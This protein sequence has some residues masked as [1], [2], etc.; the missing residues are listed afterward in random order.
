MIVFTSTRQPLIVRD[1]IA[2]GGEAIVYAV[3]RQPDAVAKIYTAQRDDYDRKLGWMIANPPDDPNQ[4]IGHPS[5]AWP[6]ERLYD[7]N[8]RLVGYLMPRI[9]GAVKLLEVFNPRL[10]AQTLPSFNWKYLHRA[11]RNLAS[12]LDALHARDYVVGDLNE[13]NILVMPTALVTLIDTDSFQARAQ[14]NGRTE[15][16]PCPVA[17]WEYTPPELQGR[18]LDRTPRLPEHDAF[19]L[20]VLIFQMLLNGSHPFRGRWLGRGDPP[21]IEERIKSGWFPHGSAAG[22]R[23]VPL[24]NML[25]LN[26]LDPTVA[27]LIE[28][29]FVE[30]HR[31]PRRRPTPDEWK[32]ALAAAEQ[33]LVECR[34]HHFFASHLSECPWCK[35]KRAGTQVPLPPLKDKTPANT[36]RATTSP[37]TK[38]R[39]TRT[40]VPLPPPPVPPPWTMRGGGSLA[41]TFP[42]P[43][44]R[45]AQTTLGKAI[46]LTPIAI[47]FALAV[48][49]RLIVVGAS[50]T[51]FLSTPDWN[52]F[53]AGA[54]TIGVG[55]LTTALFWAIIGV[56][57]GAGLGLLG[58]VLGGSFAVGNALN[59]MFSIGLW[60][61]ALAAVP[62]AMFGALL[63]GITTSKHVG[64]A[65]VGVLIG[66]MVATFAG[67]TDWLVFSSAGAL[68]G[69]LCGLVSIA[70]AVAPHTR[71]PQF[72]VDATKIVVNQL[73][74]ASAWTVMA[75]GGM[76]GICVSLVV[77]SVALVS[78]P[79]AVL[80]AAA[81]G[82][83][84]G[85]MVAMR[86]P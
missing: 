34:Q 5:I 4:S 52:A 11:A 12:A 10:R 18:A 1:P 19:G 55:A 46:T 15:L 6:R 71:G 60:G 33:K 85:T 51:R 58:A 40:F 45:F 32:V 78:P 54:R 73:S 76:V 65:L 23:I 3:Q 75:Y 66:V 72:A 56:V 62:G 53:N 28:R 7:A 74:N 27:A 81:A 79:F 77:W 48:G 17:R 31:N 20:G 39:R 14:S 86:G 44:S 9:H 83:I 69:G 50:I 67:M 29:C 8:G 26:T 2:R 47:R 36:A 61:A 38:R 80:L 70:A 63:A 21:A 84:G 25:P 64:G 35:L 24:Q 68:V 30:G 82:F 59:N 13:S 42:R 43:A 49:L 57:A 37:S 16:Y 41:S 22:G